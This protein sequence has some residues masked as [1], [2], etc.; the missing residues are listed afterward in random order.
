MIDRVLCLAGVLLTTGVCVAMD[1]PTTRLMSVNGNKFI[2][3]D[4]RHVVLHGI[5]VIEKSKAHGYLGSETAEDFA[6]LRDWGF[7]CIRL[8]MT[9]D[10]VEP[11]PGKFNDDF[12]RG[13]DRRIAWARDNGIYVFLDMHQDLFSVKYSDGAPAWATL[14]GGMPHLGESAVWSDAYFTSPA[15]QTA[16][17]NFWAN[18]PAPDG[19]GV[20]EHYARAW[21]HVAERYANDPTVIGYDLM[22]EP[23]A[24]KQV[25][26]AQLSIMSKLA[27][28]LSGKWGKIVS[29]PELVAKWSETAGRSEILKAIGDTETYKQ[30]IEVPQPIFQEFDRTK[31][32]PLFQRVTD[33]IRQVDKRHLIFLETSMASNMGVYSAIEPVKGPDGKRDPFQA[34]A[35]HGYDLV[36]DTPDVATPSNARVEMIFSRHDETAKRLA[37]PMLVGEWGGFGGVPNAAP[38]AQFIVSLFEKLLCSE[39]YWAFARDLPQVSAFA[40]LERPYPAAVAGTILEY[41]TDFANHK[42]TCAWNESAT[43]TAPTRIYLP[44]EFFSGKEKVNLA[45]KG[46]DFQIEHA[47]EG[48]RNVFLVIPPTGANNERRLSVN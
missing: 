6:N 32:M 45:P 24:G 19:V 29:V 23:F 20:Q 12:L 10:A 11:E 4:G 30:I 33:A 38:A 34:Y 26:P 9:W 37:M 7:N 16:F 3:V 39:T 2:D 22:N 40:A 35:P 41:R 27:E 48:S 5:A 47:R 31:L 1:A 43:I 44:D 15:V 13:L 25:V 42:F 18:A 17:D 14:D 28:V 36:T 21:R 8:G 46:V